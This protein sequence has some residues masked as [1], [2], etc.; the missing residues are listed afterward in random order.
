MTSTFT[1]RAIAAVFSEVFVCV[2]IPRVSTWVRHWPLRR[3]KY[4]FSL[5]HTQRSAAIAQPI[6]MRQS[7][8]QCGRVLCVRW[9]ASVSNNLCTQEPGS[10]PG[11][12]VMEFGRPYRIGRWNTKLHGWTKVVFACPLNP[13]FAHSATHCVEWVMGIKNRPLVS[14]P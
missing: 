10:N 14:V 11:S 4:G 2:R 7:K 13:H 1:A 12:C 9:L 3:K 8:W 5:V 6:P